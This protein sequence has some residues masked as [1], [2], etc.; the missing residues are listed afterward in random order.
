MVRLLLLL[1]FLL[2]FYG[3]FV[4]PFGFLWFVCCCCCCSFWIFMVRLLILLDFYGS[5]V[6]VVVVVPFGFLWFV[7]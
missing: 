4:D 7:C 6:V 2:D 5:F 3:S 1:L